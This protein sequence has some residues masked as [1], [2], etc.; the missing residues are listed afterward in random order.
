MVALGGE[1]VQ[2]LLI[3]NLGTRWGWVVSVTPRPR[4][5]PGERTSG[6]HLTGGWVGPRA[7]LDTEARRK[8]LCLCRGS[9]PGHPV[10]NQSLYD[11]YILYKKEETNS[12]ILLKNDYA[13]SSVRSFWYQWHFIIIACNSVA[14]QLMRTSDVFFFF[15]HRF[16]FILFDGRKVCS[17]FCLLSSDSLSFFWFLAISSRCSWYLLVPRFLAR[18]LLIALTMEAARTSETLVN[19]YQTTRRYNPEDSHL[20]TLRRENLKSYSSST[21]LNHLVL[22]LSL[23]LFHIHFNYHALLDILIRSVL[24]GCPNHCS[25]FACNSFKTFWIP[26]SLIFIN[27]TPYYFS[28]NTCQK[29]RIHCLDFAFVSVCNGPCLGVKR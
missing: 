22:G 3:L 2:L 17:L 8:I 21:W 4:C 9:N 1:E 14:I 23:S 6:T 5:T 28:H 29:F 20:H 19:F 25:R 10:R 7:G 16:H 26:A 13:F 27:S 24:I 18:G 15:W 11:S 12:F